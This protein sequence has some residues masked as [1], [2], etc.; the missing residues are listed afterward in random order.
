M[1]Q[2]TPLFLQKNFFVIILS[3]FSLS[4]NSRL[5]HVSLNNKGAPAKPCVMIKLV[6]ESV[7]KG[8]RHPEGDPVSPCPVGRGIAAVLKKIPSPP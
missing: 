7:S 2:F 6:S 1:C 4:S 5:N 3:L 8:L